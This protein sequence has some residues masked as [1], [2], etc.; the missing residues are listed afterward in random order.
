MGQ[1]LP[2]LVGL[3]AIP[4][5]IRELGLVGFG[6]LALCWTVVG[7]FNFFDFGFGRA[8]T[9]RV[10]EAHGSGD[11]AAA[12]A[13]ASAS[14]AAHLA[15]GVAAAGALWLGAEPLSALL[16]AAEPAVKA[17]AA[18]VLRL[19][20][21]AIPAV[22]VSNSYRGALEGLQLFGRANLIRVPFASAN[23]LVPLVGALLG[24]GLPGIVAVL[25]AVRYV[26]AGAYVA[27]FTGAAGVRRFGE[28]ELASLVR[29]GGW[30]AVS[31][32]IIPLTVTL[33]RY[34]VSG[35]LGPE[36]FAYYSAPAE[37]I[38]RILII[39]TAFSTALFPLLSDAFKRGAAQESTAAIS[40][41]LRSIMLLLAPPIA[42]VVVLAEPALGAWLGAEFAGASA[43]VLRVLALALFVNAIAFVPSAATEAAGRPDLIARYHVIELPL[44]LI[45][46]VAAVSVYGIVGA[47][48]AVLLRM[49]AMTAALSALS[50]RSGAFTFSAVA[51][52]CGRATAATVTMLAVSWGIAPRADIQWVGILVLMLSYA[53][54]VWLW[55]FSKEDRLRMKQR[56][57]P[58]GV[59]SR[60]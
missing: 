36:Q 37:L 57:S 8:V 48:V 28:G 46:L 31:N 19:L 33:E 54:V 58:A 38:T 20:A 47:A 10:S 43:A 41:A 27:A 59:L 6:L 49:I 4:V 44:Y 25:A 26:G 7:Y 14:A 3:V 16:V 42:A 32:A 21:L 24:W 23:Y 29:F 45:L 40:Q 18:A 15:L 11:L 5:T 56:L 17:E 60:S 2:L 51:K 50:V 53:G 22:L 12:A 30:V 13:L 39:P 55:V 1:G 9:K 34:V 35:Q 52:T